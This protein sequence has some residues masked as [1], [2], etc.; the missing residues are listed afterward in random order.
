VT[1]IK[2]RLLRRAA[3]VALVQLA[4][5]CDITQAAALLQLPAGAARN[6]CRKLRARIR[7]ADDGPAI[8]ASIRALAGDLDS[9]TDLVDY[10]QRRTALATWRINLGDWRTIVSGLRSRENR[11]QREHT[12]WDERKR[13]T[14]S[15]LIWIRVTQGE[16]LF[17]PH[18]YS[19]GAPPGS[20]D[21]QGLAIDRAWWRSR[22]GKRG[23]HYAELKRACDDLADRLADQ[24]DHATTVDP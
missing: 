20:P 6:A 23:H 13:M 3:A 16:H 18:R 15:A 24:I 1:G 22:T 4:E 2:P 17:T 21:D 8:L 10:G 12:N 19:P 9:R 14:A 7:H 5:N 11:L